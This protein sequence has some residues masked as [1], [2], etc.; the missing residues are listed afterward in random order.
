MLIFISLHLLNQLSI[1]IGITFFHS[2]TKLFMD[3]S[4]PALNILT[5]KDSRNTWWNTK[6]KK[7][8]KGTFGFEMKMRTV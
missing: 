2:N 5:C 8:G 3:F 7:V 6:C 1:T 4:W